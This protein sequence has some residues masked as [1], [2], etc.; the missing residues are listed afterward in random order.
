MT[1]DIL[2]LAIFLLLSYLGWRSGVAGQ[3]LRVVA[4]VSGWQP[5][6]VG[7]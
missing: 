4:A 1:L 7:T 2:L 5:G 6:R 3:A